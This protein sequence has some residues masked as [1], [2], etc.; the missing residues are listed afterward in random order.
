MSV[1]R[2]AA[3]AGRAAQYLCWHPDQS[4]RLAVAHATMVLFTLQEYSFRQRYAPLQLTVVHA[5]GTAWHLEPC[6][7]MPVLGSKSEPEP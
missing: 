4:R 2:D 5:G 3:G 1:L 7:C 6:R